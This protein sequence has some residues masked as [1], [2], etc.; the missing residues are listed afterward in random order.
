[1][2]PDAGTSI[3]KTSS[4]HL[5]ATLKLLCWN[6]HNRNRRLQEI[7]AFLETVDADIYALQEV[8]PDQLGMLQRWDGYTVHLADDFME[9]RQLAKLALVTR[10]PARPALILDHNLERGLS[11]S[12]LGRFMT[13]RECMQSQSVDLITL[14]KTLRIINLHLSAAVSPKRRRARRR[15]RWTADSHAP[16]GCRAHAPRPRH[17]RL[18]GHRDGIPP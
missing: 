17:R 15:R 2:L 12:L 1:M 16:G 13:W 4:E 5:M 9:G 10:L 14:G 3:D 7:R 6:V 18:R 11:D 8:S